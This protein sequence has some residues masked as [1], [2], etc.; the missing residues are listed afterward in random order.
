MDTSTYFLSAAAVFGAGICFGVK[1]LMT[2]QDP[3]SPSQ[4]FDPPAEITSVSQPATDEYEQKKLEEISWLW[5][6]QE[7]ELSKIAFMWR[8]QDEPP[9][10][11]AMVIR[12]HF[13][14]QEIDQ[15]YEEFVA[16]RPIV[17]GTRRT[18]I[19]KILQILD[20]E[21]DCPSVV[22]KEDR[23]NSHEAER[24]LGDELYQFLSRVPLWQHA[25]LVAR[26]YVAKFQ[27]DV[28]LP[29][30][31]IIAL[32]HD[33]GK[34]PRY[35]QKLYKSGDHPALSTNILNGIQEYA[36]LPNRNELSR[37]IMGHHFL[38]P[39]SPLAEQLKAADGEARTIEGEG[40]IAW[41][42]R[43]EAAAHDSIVVGSD[44]NKRDAT[45]E[46]RAAPSAET[47]A[48][49][50]S[51]LEI[52]PSRKRQA[53]PKGE[54]A[55]PPTSSANVYAN[56]DGSNKKGRHV[57]KEMSLPEWWDTE[58]LLAGIH[59]SIDKII[60]D[61]GG[62]TVW[63]A[64]SDP[65]TGMVWVD[66]RLV[67]DSLKKVAGNTDTKLLLADA[68]VADRRDF[69][70]TAIKELGRQGKVEVGLMGEGYYQ[71]PVN[72]VT[73]SGKSFSMFLIPFFPAAFGETIAELHNRKGSLIQKM[74]TKII[75]KQ[76][77]VKQCA[78]VS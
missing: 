3:V 23:A 32:G 34:I 77:E 57:C 19:V 24:D 55:P 38:V 68:N 8:E 9:E 50:G 63:L 6:D 36:S 17:K 72:A 51:S 53:R 54:A 2:K 25:L 33:L 52:K 12:P 48:G 1:S 15:F 10:N 69:L 56:E 73:G 26:K 39:G 75:P 7:I 67:W 61:N 66:E 42:D 16:S 58:K 49:Q 20:K 13:D 30:A 41:I 45:E 4:S 43:K 28:M 76:F 78:N 22:G 35:Y 40:L 71:V 64:V 59:E 29:D 74:V 31:L 37:V 27:Y 47:V 14:H 11:A 70:Y 18:V 5:I 60:S 46:G 44:L 62:K 65:G 21:G